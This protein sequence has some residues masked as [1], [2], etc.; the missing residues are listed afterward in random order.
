MI[1]SI[2]K[3]RRS[4]HHKVEGRRHYNRQEASADAH[5]GNVFVTLGTVL[6]HLSRGAPH[7]YDT[8]KGLEMPLLTA[9]STEQQLNISQTSP[10][11]CFFTFIVAYVT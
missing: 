8:E 1:A 5:Q 3:H 7:T 2:V 11:L 10:K 6:T 9:V 4:R